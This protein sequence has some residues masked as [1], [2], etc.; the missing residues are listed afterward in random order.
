RPVYYT[1][2][3]LEAWAWHGDPALWYRA[4]TVLFA[5]ALAAGALSLWLFCGPLLAIGGMALLL[6]GWYWRDVWAHLG[7][8]EQ[9]A[10]VGTAL[11]A[12]GAAMVWRT[13][14]VTGGLCLAA[15]GTLVAA[16]CKENFAV[17]LVPLAFAAWHA[18]RSHLQAS[19]AAFIAACA[20]VGFIITA[21]ALGL[22]HA[23]TDI[24]G[25]PLG[26]GARLWWVRGAPGAFVAVLWAVFLLAAFIATHRARQ[27][28]GATQAGDHRERAAALRALVR[29]AAI[30]LAVVTALVSSQATYYAPAW[31]RFGARYD[32]PGRLTDVLLLVGAA[33]FSL[34]WLRLTGRVRPALLLERAAPLLLVLLAAR[35]GWLPVRE[36]A[37]ANAANTWALRDI[38]LEARDSA[39][40]RPG[41]PV[42]I[43][44]SGDAE[45]EPAGAVITLLSEL[46]APGPYYLSPEPRPDG[47]TIRTADLDARSGEGYDPANRHMASTLQLADALQLSSGRDVVLTV[48][49]YLPPTLRCDVRP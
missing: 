42:I 34:R 17:L 30:V 49:G 48:R 24:Y 41:A 35:H 21:V 43:A 28:G 25:T 39:V 6:S 38:L 11:V 31:P 36:S 12:L 22:R 14:A 3:V 32:F 1:Q 47:V 8:A 10:S 4:R 40:A 46:G 2:R 27:S 20:G 26:P 33:A 45:L 37:A 19:L 5:A 13:K 7:P 29:D 18:H 44:F 23:T 9:Y 16:G 15:L